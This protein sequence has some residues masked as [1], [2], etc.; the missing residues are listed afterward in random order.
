MWR[1]GAGL[2]RCFE[3][4]KKVGKKSAVDPPFQGIRIYVFFAADAAGSINARCVRLLA[5][6][7]TQKYLRIILG[8][9]LCA[10]MRQ[11][12]RPIIRNNICA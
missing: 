2:H 7:Y 10:F 9:V 11:N 5:P 4:G 3:T 8:R 12:L 1:F 6:N